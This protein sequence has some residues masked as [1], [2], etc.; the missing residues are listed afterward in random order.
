MLIIQI[1]TFV[2]LACAIQ[3][4]F[5]WIKEARRGGIPSLPITRRKTFVYALGLLIVLMVWNVLD[6]KM[7]F[8]DQAI[9]SQIQLNQSEDARRIFF[10]Y[11]NFQEKMRGGNFKA[12]YVY[13]SPTYRQQN[14]LE[15]FQQQF[16]T[17]YFPSL[18]P[19]P[20][21][22]T[23]T[24]K[25]TAILYPDWDIYGSL[26]QSGVVLFLEKEQDDWYFTGEVSLILD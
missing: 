23:S 20:K 21:L 17:T 11:I 19:E 22:T 10:R 2:G 5:S 25:S 6:W 16:S 9:V 13:M 1:L 26:D 4:I 12:A 15:A 24:D 8:S 3:H 14:S 7:S 18:N